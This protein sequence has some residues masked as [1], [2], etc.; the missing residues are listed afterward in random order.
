LQLLLQALTY[1]L[2]GH[3]NAVNLLAEQSDREQQRQELLAQK[4][5][6]L[7]GQQVLHDLQQKK[8][9]D[10]TYSQASTTTIPDMAQYPFRPPATTVEDM[11]EE[12]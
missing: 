3:Q 12:V 8:Y 11:D 7:Q 1:H 10:D 9:G 4:N 5:A 2:T 6:L